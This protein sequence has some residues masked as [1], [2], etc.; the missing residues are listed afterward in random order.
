MDYFFQM[1]MMLRVENRQQKKDLAGCQEKLRAA[2]LERRSTKKESDAYIGHIKKL[3]EEVE[4][5]KQRADKYKERCVTL[6]ER[7]I[8][9]EP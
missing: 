5:T 6:T 2:D 9:L 7:L 1:A 4:K 8:V 3:K